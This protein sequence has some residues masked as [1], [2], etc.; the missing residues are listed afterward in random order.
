MIANTNEMH[1]IILG[2]PGAGKGTQAK[3]I[4]EK[5]NIPSIST[6]DLLRSAASNPQDETSREIASTIGKG[7]LVSND[8]IIKVLQKRLS[9]DD[10]KN[11]FLL[12]GFP[13]SLEQAKLMDQLFT[14][15]GINFIINVSVDVETLVKR[16]M[17]RFS[18]KKCNTIYNKFFLKP[19][20]DGICDNCGSTDFLFRN[21]D[22]ETIIR[23]RMSVYESETSPLIKYYE[24]YKKSNWQMKNFD[25]N[26]NVDTLFGEIC[27][28][29]NNTIK[30]SQNA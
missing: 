17:G 26:K 23:K 2:A 10:C 9:Q 18:C 12:D 11:G 25:G 15:S 8:L 19:K 29:L 7:L 16:L 13:R 27:E 20:K 4:S 24:S 28:Y 22:E 5:Y 30:E 21:D 14:D 1:I 3:M 6:G